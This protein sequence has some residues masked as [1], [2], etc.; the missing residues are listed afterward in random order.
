MLSEGVHETEKGFQQAVVELAERLGWRV[1]R[2]TDSRRS[3]EGWPDLL[4]VHQTHRDLF[5]AELKRD[6]GRLSAAQAAWLDALAACGV[7]VYV[8]RPYDWPQIEARLT[9][10]PRRA[11]L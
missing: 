9:R 4:C 3:P 2:V 11:D 5:A 10:G 8:W 1:H 7:D 6:G